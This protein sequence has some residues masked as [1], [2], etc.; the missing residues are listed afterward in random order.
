MTIFVAFLFL[1]L[2]GIHPKCKSET[3]KFFG[4][5]KLPVKMTTK[6]PVNT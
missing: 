3:V 6:L 5:S 1:L 4:S 2:S